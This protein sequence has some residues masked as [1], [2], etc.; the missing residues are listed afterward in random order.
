MKKYSIQSIKNKKYIKSKLLWFGFLLLWF[1]TISTYTFRIV[2]VI[3]TSMEPTILDGSHY[4]VH[5]Q[6]YSVDDPKRFDVIVFYINANEDNYYIKRIIGL[7]GEKI[8]IDNGKI[9]I[10]GERLLDSVK[11][12]VT[13]S[14]LAKDEILLGEDE[15]FVL[16][17]NRTNSEDSR[18]RNFGNVNKD[19]IIGKIILN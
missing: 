13:Q 11:G 9:F 6:A 4:V 12:Q 18:M 15:Y 3:G 5:K 16:G 2:E 8:K 7:P 19:L 10:N 1:M 17:D 14:L